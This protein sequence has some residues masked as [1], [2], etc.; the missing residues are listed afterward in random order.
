MV[1]P[2][3]R[4]SCFLIVS[5]VVEAMRPNII[6]HTLDFTYKFHGIIKYTRAPIR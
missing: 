6:I 5:D 3:I 2:S 4:C 1:L